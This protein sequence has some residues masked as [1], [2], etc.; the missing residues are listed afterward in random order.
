MDFGGEADHV[1]RHR[2]L[3]IFLDSLDKSKRA[4]CDVRIEI[5]D[6]REIS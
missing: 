3:K 4:R 5:M 1:M 6:V 2:T